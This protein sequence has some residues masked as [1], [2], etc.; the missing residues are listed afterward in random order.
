MGKM[1]SFASPCPKCKKLAH[2]QYETDELKRLLEQDEVNL[3]CITCD[4]FWK[5]NPSE[6][7]N[8]ANL[9]N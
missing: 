5:P 4:H 9:I 2:Q 3:Y 8:I 7:S 1:L 6:K